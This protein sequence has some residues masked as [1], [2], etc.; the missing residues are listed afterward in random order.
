M[1]SPTK[2]PLVRVVQL[3]LDAP[4]LLGCMREQ[5]ARVINCIIEMTNAATMFPIPNIPLPVGE[6]AIST[7]SPMTSHAWNMG[8]VVQPKIVPNN[9]D[10]PRGNSQA[11]NHKRTPEDSSNEEGMDPPSAKRAKLCTAGETVHGVLHS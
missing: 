1:D 10:L 9:L 3:D 2:S 4:Q 11:P 6:A 5:A 8:V 7:L